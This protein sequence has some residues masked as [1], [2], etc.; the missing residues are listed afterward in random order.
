[1]RQDDIFIK[2]TYQDL[3]N[4][5]L[6]NYVFNSKHKLF[7]NRKGIKMTPK[8]FIKLNEDHNYTTRSE[9]ILYP[10]YKYDRTRGSSLLFM[11]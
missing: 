7:D 3:I 4:T 1:M 8:S 9:G 10:N 2:L 6:F 11:Y 5:K